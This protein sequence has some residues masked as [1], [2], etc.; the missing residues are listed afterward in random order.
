M[1]YIFIGVNIFDNYTDASNFIRKNG[2]TFPI[3]YNSNNNQVVDFGIIG[4]PE[5]IFI[6]KNMSM[7][8]KIIGPFDEKELVGSL[9]EIHIQ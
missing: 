9:E 7:T 6:S 2:I 4:V 1:N 3:S 5:T 8:K